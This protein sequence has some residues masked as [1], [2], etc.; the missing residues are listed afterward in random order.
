MD[1]E[2]W[3]AVIAGFAGG[4]VMSMVMKAMAKAGKTEMDLAL[5]EGSMFTG[6]RTKAM[7]IGMVMHLVLLSGV[8]IGSVYAVLFAAFGVDGGDLWWVG[9]LFGIAHGAMAGIMMAALPRMHPR[10]VSD[11]APLAR[12]VPTSA[13][14]GSPVLTG[15]PELRLRPPGLFGKYYGETMPA[16]VIMVHMLYGVTV[17][18]VYWWLAR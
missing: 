12:A 14:P 11:D 8:V 1:Y 5:I 17:G 6:D 2:F 3:P 4:L 15:E 7:A 13:R 9:A 16:M 18:L 10:M